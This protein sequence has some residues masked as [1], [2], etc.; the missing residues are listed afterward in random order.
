[1]TNAESEDIVTVASDG[2]TV[3]K[4][5]EPD[6][7]PV[8]AIAFNIDSERD[9][10]VSVRLVDTVPDDVAP[11]N[12]GFHPKYGAEFWDV[13]DGRIVF[14]REL[15]PEE[16]YTT[17]YGLRGGDA[18]TATKFMS[19]PTIDSVDPPL[20]EDDEDVDTALNA[21]EIEGIDVSE[22]DTAELSVPETGAQKSATAANGESDD[23]AVSEVDSDETTAD[24]KID[25]PGPITN[26]PPSDTVST[27]EEADGSIDD[28]PTEGTEESD[29]SLGSLD[30]SGQPSSDIDETEPTTGSEPIEDDSSATGVDSLV[31]E[32]ADEIRNTDVD[33]DD[34]LELRDALG[35]DLASASIEARI[36]HLQ[37][38]T[39]DLQAYTD[40]FEAFLDEEGDAQTLIAEARDGYEETSDRLDAIET[41]LED[42]R[43]DL[44]DQL[45][46]IN[47]TIDERIDSELEEIRS[48][49]ESLEQS[50]ESESEARTE[51][52]SDLADLSA[53]IEEVTE[54]RDRLTNALSGLAGGVSSDSDD[55]TGSTEDDVSDSETEADETEDTDEN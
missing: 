22:E 6:D 17:V 20:S 26:E 28:L 7:F 43:S 54:M 38:E 21:A 47:E 12:I 34:L 49:L 53:E 33:D 44:D 36:E 4:S 32:L 41:E 13:E 24:G 18:D 15:A 46:T 3:E 48:D 39:S 9:A 52:E 40:A 50:I 11:E 25:E 23:L 55:D 29:E 14:N 42:A 10:A 45:E 8:P 30:V 51:I 27:G 2:V 16:S 5:F 37:S 19:E 35:L 31:S 1:M